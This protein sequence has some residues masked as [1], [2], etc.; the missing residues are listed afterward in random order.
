MNGACPKRASVGLVIAI[1]ILGARPASPAGAIS[2]YATSDQF[3]TEPVEK[4]FLFSKNGTIATPIIKSP[5]EQLPS[6]GNLSLSL[7]AKAAVKLRH[8]KEQ[9]DFLAKDPQKCSAQGRQQL[10]SLAS[11]L[12]QLVG[13]DGS[14]PDILGQAFRAMVKYRN[15]KQSGAC[16]EQMT[17]TTSYLT[18]WKA[19]RSLLEEGDTLR[20]R[21]AGLKADCDM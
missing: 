11:E 19:V 10:D 3:V 15:D 21:I 4:L 14:T 9:L 16:P 13:L 1:A 6:I 12:K 20:Q 17:C 2:D 8:L 18:V 5:K 7:A